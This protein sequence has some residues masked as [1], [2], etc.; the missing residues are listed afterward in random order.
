MVLGLMSGTS[1]DGIDAALCDIT[2]A[3]GAPRI[4]LV[5]SARFSYPKKL[6]SRLFSLLSGEG[7]VAE[8][9]QLN[10]AIGEAFSR[11]A[12]KGM[13]QK[14]I[15]LI[16]SS[17][18][19][20]FHSPKTGSTLQIGSP[21]VIAD[22]TGV[23][24]W[25]DFRSADMA[26]G[27]EGAPLAPVV[28]LP[29]FVEQRINVSALNI[30]GIANITHI[31]AG[32]KTLSQLVA[33]DTGPGNMLIDLATTRM[34]EGLFD[35]GGHIAR[36]GKVKERLLDKLLGH[37]FF[38]KKTPKSTG[39]EQFGEAF[40]RWAGIDGRRKWDE[41]MVATFTELTAR[42]VTNE[43]KKLA[44]ANRPTDRLVICGGGAKNGFL[45]ERITELSGEA[46]DVVTSDKLGAPCDVIEAMLIALL[47]F[48]ADSGITQ[49]LRSITGSKNSNAPLGS[50]TPAKPL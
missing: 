39:R 9:C 37:R 33:Y 30:G 7:S 10:V 12:L 35:R 22:R 3:R 25:S 34:G 21:A 15:E 41:N 6:R 19:T 40:I 36:M 18:Q 45:V 46:I 42:T 29:L 49:D 28:H 24:V 43:I 32:A 5:S 50:Y 48:F 8:V 16:G 27:G 4:R 17:G 2:M 44:K 1:M 20:I 13:G 31:P 14:R 23:P 26:G 11:A 38:K 47:A